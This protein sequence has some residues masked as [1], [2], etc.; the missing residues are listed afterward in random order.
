MLSLLKL[1]SNCSEISISSTKKALAFILLVEKKNIFKAREI[2]NIYK[3]F[4]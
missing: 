1:L 2:K 4:K 3:D